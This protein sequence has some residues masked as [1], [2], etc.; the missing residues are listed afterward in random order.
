MVMKQKR[1]IQPEP[2]PLPDA[3]ER[4]WVK[5]AA[6]G[7]QQAFNLLAEKYSRR[8]YNIGLKMLCNA[9]DAADM[10]QEALIKIYRN[11]P[12]FRGDSAFS[13]WV[14]RVS[15]NTCRDAL[16]AA[17]RNRERSFS[18]FGDEEESVINF[19]I[20]DYSAMP[21]SVYL[22][23]EDRKYLHALIDGL[24]P[25][26]RLVVVL[27]EVSG[28]SYQEIADSVNISVGTVKSRLNRARAAMRSR[29]LADAEQYPHLSRLIGKGGKSDE[30]LGD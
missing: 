19:D 11:L 7:D 2:V 9:D 27:R 30:M 24:S 29:L 20:A 25:K 8:I 28:L 5:Q 22:D 16:R 10:T 18:D 1:L 12:S 14:Y 21:E 6:R 17:Y 4:E 26:Y 15:V 13:T 23:G 3:A